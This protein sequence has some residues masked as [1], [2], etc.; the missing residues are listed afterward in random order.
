V[1][2]A[3]PTHK[4]GEDQRTIGKNLSL[5]EKNGTTKRFI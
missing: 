5:E 2:E 1:L 4:L 3:I